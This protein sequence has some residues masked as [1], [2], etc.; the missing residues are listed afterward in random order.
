MRH[1]F[2]RLSGW[3]TLLVALIYPVL[4]HASGYDKLTYLTFSG[5]V[6]IPGAT[7]D[8]GTYQFRLANP[9]SAVSVVVVTS[10]D[11]KR[12]YALSPTTRGIR[13]KH[14]AGQS[15][16][17]FRETHAGVPPAIRGWFSAGEQTGYEFVYSRRQAREIAGRVHRPGAPAAS[18]GPVAAPPGMDG[19][20]SHGA[21]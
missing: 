20:V 16:V 5:P 19:P 6:Q 14:S 17:V 4:A 8:A 21:R 10:E 2:L 1:A 13:R 15:P 7:L 12:V 18:I 11:G 9:G 3:S